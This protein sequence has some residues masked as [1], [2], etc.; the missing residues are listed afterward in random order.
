MPDK[1]TILEE[2]QKLIYGDRQDAYGSV[3]E[4]FSNIAAGWSVIAGVPLTPEQVGLMMVWVKIS[5]QIH[6]PQRDN[7]VDGAGYF[8]C[9]DKIE[10][11]KVPC[12]LPTKR[13]R[14]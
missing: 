10:K 2:A 8:G 13:K 6:K 4:N 11:E 12:S 3:T 9:I 14:K 5:R 1:Q 7:L